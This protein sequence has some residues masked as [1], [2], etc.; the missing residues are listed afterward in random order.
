[1]LKPLSSA[2][3]HALPR[4]AA[5]SAPSENEIETDKRCSRPS[6][7]DVPPPTESLFLGF[8]PNPLTA[9]LPVSIGTDYTH[10]GKRSRYHFNNRNRNATVSAENSRSDDRVELTPEQQQLKVERGEERKSDK[11][12]K[13]EA[14]KKWWASY[15]RGVK[16]WQEMYMAERGMRW[17]RNFLRGPAKK[18]KEGEVGKIGMGWERRVGRQGRLAMAASTLTV[19]RYRE[20]NLALWGSELSTVMLH[21]MFGK[22]LGRIHVLDH[23]MECVN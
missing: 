21:D 3:A 4:P 11:Q 5:S 23:T 14:K 12:L 19:D 7:R 6:V 1:V 20:W 2:I 16:G 22:R 9:F 17:G 18:G 13:K 10:A 15:E 8:T